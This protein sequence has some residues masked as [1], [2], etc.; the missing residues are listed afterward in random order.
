MKGEG[1]NTQNEGSLGACREAYFY[2]M[3]SEGKI[4][5]LAKELQRTQR[6]LALSSSLLDKLLSHSHCD[7][8]IMSDITRQSVLDTDH[9]RFRQYTFWRK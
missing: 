5:F 4:E 3:S 8:K 1:M 7:G 2:E 9:Y 6:E